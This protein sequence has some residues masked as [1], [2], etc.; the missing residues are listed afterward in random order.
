MWPPVPPAAITTDGSRWA[1]VVWAGAASF[2][3]RWFGGPPCTVAAADVPGNVPAVGPVDL[4]KPLRLHLVGVG[5]AGMSAI[6]TVLTG[7]GHHVSGSDLKVSRGLDRLRAIGVR[8]DIGHAADH[9]D[10]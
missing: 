2:I 6:A 1:V 4:S 5:G 10:D 8:V 9:V 3:G 7:M